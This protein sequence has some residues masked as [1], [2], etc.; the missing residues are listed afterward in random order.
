MKYYYACGTEFYPSADVCGFWRL[1]DDIISEF[2]K[3]RTQ[4][5]GNGE[6]H[7]IYIYIIT[8]C[9]YEVLTLQFNFAQNF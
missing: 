6:Y 5:E 1:K 9:I 4:Y 8:I 7:K 2:Q 3:A